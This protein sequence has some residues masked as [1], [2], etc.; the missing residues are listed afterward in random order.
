[1]KTL[2]TG[3]EG[4]ESTYALLVRSEEKQRT[5]I[6][7]IF[8]TLL[9]L[10]SLFALSQFAREAVT[11]PAPSFAPIHSERFPSARCLTL[12]AAATPNPA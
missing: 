8:Y 11:M 1:M 12:V 10:S 4:F 5:R 7:A 6:E 2:S 3:P 9:V